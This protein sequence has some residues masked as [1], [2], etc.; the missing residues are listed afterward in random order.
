MT[1]GSSDAVP[2]TPSRGEDR[3]DYDSTPGTEDL[4]TNGRSVSFEG[5]EFDHDAKDED[6]YGDDALEDKAPQTES[7]AN[8]RPGTGRSSWRRQVS[9]DD[10]FSD[11]GKLFY[12]D[13]DENDATT[14]LT[15]QIRE[16]T[17]MEEMDP[18]PTFELAQL[19]KITPFRGKLD[20][21]ENSMQWLRDVVYEMTGTHT[22]PNEWRMVFQ[23]SLR[24]GAVVVLGSH[25]F[26][27]GP[28]PTSGSRG[29][30][31][32]PVTHGDM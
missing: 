16:L 15:W 29:L 26:F 17:A 6:D 31:N 21:S 5:T 1:K 14:D 23:L 12:Q 8:T 19:G 32:S 11:E 27:Y 22:P 3:D 4:V 13:D 18:T 20:E 25:K 28:L 2:A 7:T 24:D 9:A 10:S 30:V